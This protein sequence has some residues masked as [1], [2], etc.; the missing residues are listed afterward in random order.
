MKPR[1]ARDMLLFENRIPLL[2]LR[3]MFSLTEQTTKEVDFVPLVLNFFEFNAKTIPC[4]KNLTNRLDDIPHLL[5]LVYEALVS[6]NKRKDLAP[7]PP[8]ELNMK[9]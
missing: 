3:A 5:G 7:G 6:G 1:L 8:V 9:H 4:D 2:V